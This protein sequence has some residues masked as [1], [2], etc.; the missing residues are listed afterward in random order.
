MS[1]YITLTQI[2]KF[3]LLLRKYGRFI[4]NKCCLCGQISLLKNSCYLDAVGHNNFQEV[5]LLLV[6]YHVCKLFVRRLK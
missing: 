4:Y 3:T 1:T 6:R 5:H 2:Y